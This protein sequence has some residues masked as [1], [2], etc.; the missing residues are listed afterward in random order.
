MAEERL[1]LAHGGGG[2]KTKELIERLIL[3]AVGEG[4][5]PPVGD[6][7]PLPDWPRLHLTTDAY[8]VRPLFF[9]GGDIGRLAVVGTANDLAVSGARP[10]YLA[11]SVVAAEG[12]GME[13]LEAVFRSVGRALRETGMVLLAGDTKVVEKGALDGLFLTTTGIGESL[14]EPAPRP[15][16]C[17]PGDV[18]VLS[19][20]PGRHGAAVL[21]AREGMEL[22]GLRSDLGPLWPLVEAAAA[23]GV[24]P[25]FMRDLTRGGL[26][27]ALNDLAAGSGL[28]AVVEEEAVPR[29]EAAEALF[30]LM[31]IDRYEAASEG[32]LVAVVGEGEAEA[33]LDAWRG[34]AAA[35]AVVGRLEERGEFPVLLRTVLGSER[36][37]EAPYGE[38]LPRIC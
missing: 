13:T 30:E 24:R 37:L 25:R 5:V 28:T 35:A 10:R 19:G 6:A 33:L 34:L 38:Q 27:M 2:R 16:L 9:P 3:P 7:E 17:R 12:L 1:L 4:T 23:A 20:P 32:T 18:L 22:P 31:G 21:A 11:L 26:A 36:L 29:D 8:T 15:A 14:W